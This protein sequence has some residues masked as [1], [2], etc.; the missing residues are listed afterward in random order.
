[1]SDHQVTCIKKSIRQSAH[2]RITSIGGTNANGSRWSL[3]QEEAIAGIE[4]GK[5]RFWVTANGH[6]VWVIVSTSA[7]GNKYLKTQNDGEHP[8]NLLSLPECP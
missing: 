4:S 1:M 7:A 8:N 2:E 3:S 5:W 6:S